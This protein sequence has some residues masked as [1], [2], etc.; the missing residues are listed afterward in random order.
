MLLT[1]RVFVLNAIMKVFIEHTLFSEHMVWIKTIITQPDHCRSPNL[2][3][4]IREIY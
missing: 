1:S 2:V 4:K 3:E